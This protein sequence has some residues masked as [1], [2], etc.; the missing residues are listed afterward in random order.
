MKIKGC[1]DATGVLP[2][3]AILAKC[4]SRHTQQVTHIKEM[5]FIEKE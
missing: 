3:S 2:V 1:P 4:S 5:T